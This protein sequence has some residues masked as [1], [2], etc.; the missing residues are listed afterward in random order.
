MAYSGIPIIGFSSTSNIN[1][2]DLIP[3]IDSRV[4][5][6]DNDGN[7]IM[8]FFSNPETGQLVKTDQTTFQWYEDKLDYQNAT[9]LTG[10]AVVA[11]GITQVVTIDMSDVAIGQFYHHASSGQTFQVVAIGTVVPHVSAEVTIKQVPYSAATTVIAAG[12]PLNSQ[13]VFMVEGGYYPPPR[14]MQP[15]PFSNIVG[16]RGYS[17]GITNT[18]LGSPTW[19]GNP[20]EH[21]EFAGLSKVKY[22]SERM[23][24]FG[25]RV[26]EANVA[27]DNGSGSGSWTGT[28]RM[29]L[30]LYHRVTT[31]VDLYGGALT[32]ATLDNW[33]NTAVWSGIDQGSRSKLGLYGP[34][35]MTDIN[36]FAKNRYRKI[37]D[38]SAARDMYGMDIQ[39]YYFNGGRKLYLVEE[40]EFTV[41]DLRHTIFA[42]D[43]KHIFIRHKRPDYIEVRPDAQPNNAD[44]IQTSFVMEDGLQVGLEMHHARLGWI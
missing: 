11:A 19:Y 22:D 39:C 13:G 20:Y 33:L 26:E 3:E 28:L 37:E 29:S 42:V 25:K 2:A 8:S 17:I 10:V 44:R 31:N 16:L 41:G 9:L 32:E 1:A 34:D 7:P 30:G 14:G 40:R 6:S 23:Y 38:M 12:Q 35:A 43:P 5:Y 27:Q 36:S 15:T 4:L 21:S 24:I 18:Q